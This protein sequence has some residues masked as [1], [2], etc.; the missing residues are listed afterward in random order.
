MVHKK[1]RPKKAVNCRSQTFN[2]IDQQTGG[3]ISAVVLIKDAFSVCAFS[4]FHSGYAKL[5]IYGVDSRA[6]AEGHSQ[7]GGD[8]YRQR[9]G[10]AG[11]GQMVDHLVRIERRHVDSKIFS[12]LFIIFRPVQNRHDQ[13]IGFQKII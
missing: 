11:L 5:R 8:L 12:C 3:G 7:A 9:Y 6:A 1:G 2:D 13:L 4:S 10:S